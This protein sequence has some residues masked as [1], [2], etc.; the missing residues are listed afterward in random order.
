M[1]GTGLDA[2]LRVPA[3]AMRHGRRV[4]LSSPD[5]VL[6]EEES[7]ILRRYSQLILTYP[8]RELGG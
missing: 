6:D 3:P 8:A 2:S 7:K 4:Y 1:P 5:S